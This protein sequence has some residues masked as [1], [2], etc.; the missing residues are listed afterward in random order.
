[1]RI[2]FFT[3]LFKSCS[4]DEL[5]AF[6]A[7]KGFD[8]FD[9]AVRPDY[10]VNEG[11][12]TTELVPF[13]KK[14]AAA[15]LSIELATIGM[16][17]MDL[18]DP[19]TEAAW[20]ACAEAGVPRIKLGYGVWSKEKPWKEQ[21]DEMRRY[22]AGCGE[23]SL[24]HG[25]KSVVHTHSGAYI[26]LNASSIRHLL[27]GLDPKGVGAYLDFAHLAIDGEPADLAIATSGEYLSMVA[28]KNMRYVASHEEGAGD[29]PAGS[30][31]KKELCSLADGLANWPDVVAEL[32]AAGYDGAI[33]MHGEYHAR[34]TVESVSEMMLP[35][36]EYLK[37]LLAG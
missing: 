15:G 1:M 17:P 6:A 3:K 19:A 26:G 7:E 10:P 31:W 16:R 20:A 18:S 30:I 5:V 11:N 29:R 2:V 36:L 25:P 8:G 12:I 4:T 23:L 32:K 21:F 35:D 33:S 28:A 27:D 37:G 13:S 9:L 24:K 22:V 34:H 14:A